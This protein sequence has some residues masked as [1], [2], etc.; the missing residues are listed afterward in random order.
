[1]NTID[2][3]V[4]KN[5]KSM[6]LGYNLVVLVK[7]LTQINMKKTIKEY[8]CHITIFNTAMEK[9]LWVLTFD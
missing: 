8:N 2:V 3:L 5:Q 7:I 9:H 6:S 4:H 1:M